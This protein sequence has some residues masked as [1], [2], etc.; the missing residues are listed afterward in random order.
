MTINNLIGYDPLAWLDAEVIEEI[1]PVVIAKKAT[2]SRAKA[3]VAPVAIIDSEPAAKLQ[4]IPKAQD[5]I[6]SV[7]D[8]PES[9]EIDVMIDGDVD[10][11][12]DTDEHVD[13]EFEISI[14]SPQNDKDVMN[15]IVDEVK[16]MLVE[17]IAAEVIES[18]P[19]EIIEPLIELG[20]DATMKHLATLY[21]TVKHVLAAHDRFEIN[22]S[23]VTTIDTATLQLLVSLKKDAPRLNKTV[24][25]IYPSPRFIESAKLLNLLDV[26]DVT[27]V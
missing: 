10:I 5:E 3:K 21:D 16:E 24:D 1:P 9:V 26:L 25:I 4:T 15:Q 22:A 19:K 13:I 18:V 23:N 12:I 14:E 2:K 7:I 27:D 6:E 17:T 20:S 11:T 8:T